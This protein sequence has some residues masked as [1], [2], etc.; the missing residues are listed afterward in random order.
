MLKQKDFIEIEFTGRVKDGDIFDSNRKEDLAKIDSRLD[1]KGVKPFIFSLGQK[2][3]LEGIDEFLIGK[4]FKPGIEYEIPLAPEKAFGKRNPELIKT[5]PLKV[6]KAQNLNPVPG[7]SFNFDGQIGRVISVS[8]G[9]IMTD[10]NNPVAGKDVTYKVKI[11]KKIDDKN[12]QVASLLDFF[13]RKDFKFEIKEKEKRL[14]IDM[15]EELAKQPG[16]DKFVELFK[17]K[18]KEILGLDME[19]KKTSKANKHPTKK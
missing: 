10:F 14:I 12:H 5:I 6:F 4:E 11:L 19:I 1:A 7:G 9:R 16:F 15:G 17:D 13:F 3:F 2:M 18:F 8:G